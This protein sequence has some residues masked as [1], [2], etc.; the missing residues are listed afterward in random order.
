MPDP[1]TKTL[2]PALLPSPAL[3]DVTNLDHAVTLELR[4][5]Q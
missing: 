1:T 4:R 3:F 5:L 2:N